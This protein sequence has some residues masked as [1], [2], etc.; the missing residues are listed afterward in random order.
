MRLHLKDIKTG[1]VYLVNSG[2]EVSVTPKPSDW[3][4]PPLPLKL[5]NAHLTPLNVYDVS[6]CTL[7]FEN[8][9]VLDWQFYIADVPFPILGYDALVHF[10]LLPDLR[11][12]TLVDSFG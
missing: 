1:L 4:Y 6:R 8:N 12:R 9:T 7:S 10:H 2:A 11:N 3:R 5:Y